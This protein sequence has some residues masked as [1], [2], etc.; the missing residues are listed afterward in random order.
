MKIGQAL[1][2]GQ[3]FLLLNG[4]CI[5]KHSCERILQIKSIYPEKLLVVANIASNQSYVKTVKT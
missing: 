5:L 4:M 3:S 2:H 1:D